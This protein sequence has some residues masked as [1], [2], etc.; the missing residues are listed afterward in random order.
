MKKI[1]AVLLALLLCIGTASAEDAGLL[2]NPFP[3]FTVTDTEGNT[4]KLSEALNDHEAVLINFW[5]T[6]CGPCGNEFPYLQSLY[7]KYGDRVAFIALSTDDD[8]TMEKIAAYRQER[9]I[10]FPMGRDE[11]AVLYRQLNENGI[12]DTVIVDRFGNTAFIRCGAFI[13]EAAAERTLAAFLGDDYNETKVLTDIPADTST[14]AFPVY[15]Q[16][17]VHVEN[18]NA[19]KI[20]MYADQDDEAMEVYIVP[21]STA[22]LRLE[23]AAGD[24]PGKIIYYDFLEGILVV[25]DLLDAQRGSFVYDQPLPDGSD[26]NHMTGGLLMTYELGTSDPALTECTIITGEEY[27]GELV[28]ALEGTGYTNVRWEFAE[29]GI[30]AETALQAYTIHVT[31]QFNDPVPEVTVNFCTDTA[32]VPRESDESGTV[33]FDGAPDVYHVQIVDV[34]D[35]YSYDEEFELYTTASYGEWALRVKKD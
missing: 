32:C 5:A 23:L 26:G 22:H 11:G 20:L 27:I 24:E 25:Q 9:G 15:A 29:N 34:P 7:E 1:I 8:D 10:T 13:N 30:Q 2:G 35:G 33:T 31:D 4:F 19:K 17:A 16:R 6:W 18:E 21:D 3:E 28:Q 12:P 14:Q